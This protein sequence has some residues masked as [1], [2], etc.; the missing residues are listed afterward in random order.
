[1]IPVLMDAR[2]PGSS[3]WSAV[4]SA[5]K[6]KVRGLEDGELI[7]YFH[8][9]DVGHIDVCEDMEMDLPPGT[10]RVRVELVGAR[11]GS[12]VFVDME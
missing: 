4:R 1:M 12:R 10:D 5:R 6:I 3:G 9:G 11:N 7:I 8:G 2:Y